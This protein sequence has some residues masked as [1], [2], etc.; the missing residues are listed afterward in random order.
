MGRV[1]GPLA[2]APPTPTP[3]ELS[4][5]LLRPSVPYDGGGEGGGEDRGGTFT[6]IYSAYTTA[7]TITSPTPIL[8]KCRVLVWCCAGSGGTPAGNVCQW[9]DAGEGEGGPSSEH[10][11][12][13]AT[14]LRSR[15]SLSR[16]CVSIC[17]ERDVCQPPPS[18][19]SLGLLLGVTLSSASSSSSGVLQMPSIA[20][21]TWI[22][23]IASVGSSDDRLDE[24]DEGDSDP[25]REHAT[26]W[27][28][29]LLR[30]VLELDRMARGVWVDNERV[31]NGAEAL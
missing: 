31:D 16:L 6:P 9:T 29:G 4:T 3:E 10:T 18:L 25:L 30:T 5:C 22:A 17:S 2:V 13:T 19:P 20:V 27:G 12:R 28:L 24:V 8:H 15:R 23:P 11:R 26:R 21:R 7:A 1:D 14:S